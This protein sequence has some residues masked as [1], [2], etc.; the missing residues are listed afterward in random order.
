M[1]VEFYIEEQDL[2]NLPK[3][4]PSR[5]AAS[6]RK[7]LSDD[8][9][10][11]YNEYGQ[12]HIVV[13]VHRK[14]WDFEGIWGTNWSNVHRAFHISLC[15]YDD[16]NWA[17]SFGTMYHEMMHAVDALVFTMTGVSLSKELGLDWD[18][19]VVHGG[20]PDK[21]FTTEWE[22]INFKQNTQAL[23]RFGPVIREA[24]AKRKELH[25]Q[26]MNNQK[27]IIRLLQSIVFLLR[28]LMARKDTA[29]LK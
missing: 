18:E 22:W 9:Y 27:I 16:K 23:K 4:S 24:Y 3:D 17:N 5:L 8:V 6:W 10:K 12:D 29:N 14:H 25:E 26:Y 20:R 13:L 11:R 28:K 19:F 7:E 1:D 21:E 15:R 2:R